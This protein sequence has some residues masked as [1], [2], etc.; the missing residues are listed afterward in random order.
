MCPQDT[1]DPTPWKSWRAVNHQWT[2]TC[3]ISALAADLL[4]KGTVL[5]TAFHFPAGRVSVH[6][7]TPSHV[8]FQRW[9]W[10]SPE[11]TYLNQWIRFTPLKQIQN[12]FWFENLGMLIEA[13]LD[14]LKVSQDG[15]KR[16]TFSFSVWWNCTFESHSWWKERPDSRLINWM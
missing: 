14:G 1:K 8:F 10:N 7:W 3:Q 11:G 12:G 9:W 4:C 6:P 2:K 5:I 13:S 15:K 16:H